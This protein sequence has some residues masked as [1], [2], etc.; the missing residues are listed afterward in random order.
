MQYVDTSKKIVTGK[1]EV[2]PGA[3]ITEN[4]HS[5]TQRTT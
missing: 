1:A 5:K 3:E 2:E 4:K